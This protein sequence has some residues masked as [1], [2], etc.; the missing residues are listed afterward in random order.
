MGAGVIRAYGIERRSRQRLDRAIAA[1]YRAEMGAAK[2]FALMFPLADL[3]S[4]IALA[5]VVGAAAVEGPG[6]GLDVGTVL[7]FVFL[8]NLIL[9]PIAELG[10][11]LDQTQQGIAGWARV[12]DLLDQ[13]L[14]VPEPESGTSLP[15]GAL[16][17]RVEGVDFA[18]RE[19]GLVLR[20]VDVDIAPG[21]RV[22]VVGETGSGK[23]TFTKLLCRF[24][25][26]TAGRVL[27]DGVDLRDVDKASRNRAI[28]VV[29]QDGFLFATTIGENV[30][31]GLEGSTESDALAAFDLLGLRPWLDSLPAGLHTEAG[32]RGENLSV[33]ERQLVALARAQLAG[34]GLLLLDEATS[35]VDPE[36]ERVLAS[37]L[38]RLSAG[39]TTITVAHRLSTA[40]HADS[41]LVFDGGRIVERGTHDELLALGGR[42][43]ELYASWLG[44]TRRS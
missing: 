27:I 12:F 14:D 19:G 41:V 23:T 44:N 35:A 30:R 29:P 8:V 6:W 5:A 17:V 2:Y 18:Y 11:I 1:Q 32:E 42:Y 34:P 38:G 28:R 26:P 13:P 33:G 31:Y 4:G 10:E 3:F 39:R 22:A 15:D 43:A 40:E 37:A 36:T 20:D 9:T 21:A 25:D 7:A 16:A 24:A